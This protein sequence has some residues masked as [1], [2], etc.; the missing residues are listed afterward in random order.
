MKKFPCL[1]QLLDASCLCN[2]SYF[3][4][5][6]SFIGQPTEIALVACSKHL[7]ISDRRTI[8]KRLNETAFSSETKIME[9]V[10]KEG[11]ATT[12]YVKG[13]LE[14]IIPRCSKYM[15][16]NNE[17]MIFSK[18][19]QERIVQQS[20]EMARDGLRV[21]CIACGS[22]EN[23]LTLCGIVG[24]L[25]PLRKGI[26]EAVHRI[27]ASGAKVMMVTGDAEETAI[28]IGKIVCNTKI[29]ILN[30]LADTLYIHVYINYMW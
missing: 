30:L 13:A 19:A 29:L 9:V 23:N 27:N 22:D 11:D 7:G 17:L 8:L 12:H 2:N 5:D 28:A 20:S 10:Y 1:Q 15:A 18:V 4:S 21:I 3:T 24:L 14:V 25:D 26:Q 6:N 16:L